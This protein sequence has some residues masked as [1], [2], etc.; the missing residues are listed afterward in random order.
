VLAA[1]LVQM[2]QGELRTDARQEPGLQGEQSLSAS[3]N[4]A[5]PRDQPVLPLTFEM[6]GGVPLFAMLKPGPLFECDG[7][8][9]S[10]PL[11]PSS[12]P[13]RSSADPTSAAGRG[14]VQPPKCS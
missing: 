2:F 4:L 7:S 9:V 10:A 5:A 14:D 13:G 12:S 1:A 6:D 11:A 3:T 8:A